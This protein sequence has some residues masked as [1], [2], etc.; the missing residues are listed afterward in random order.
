M[1]QILCVLLLLLALMIDVTAYSQTNP[2]NITPSRENADSIENNRR[3]SIIDNDSTEISENDS[4]T[5]SQGQDLAS[6]EKE[7]THNW[8]ECSFWA[9]FADVVFTFLG[10][11]A[12]LGTLW[13]MIKNSKGE[14]QQVNQQLSLLEQGNQQ[15]KQQI[16]NQERALKDSSEKSR[17]LNASLKESVEKINKYLTQSDLKVKLTEKK[18]TVNST[19]N[20]LW[21]SVLRRGGSKLKDGTIINNAAVLNGIITMETGINTFNDLLPVA[22]EKCKAAGK[23]C[24]DDI[25]YISKKK[26][27]G[28][29]IAQWLQD[30]KTHF[31]DLNNE[32]SNCINNMK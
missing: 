8:G 17:K 7:E 13:W 25:D 19:F 2:S 10:I 22:S 32:M 15:A 29:D 4:D 16:Q 31:D 27:K 5:S 20:S 9:T 24:L 23:I 21:N 11:I 12:A 3:D 28:E 30:M 1:K 6:Q 14:K 18:D 26:K